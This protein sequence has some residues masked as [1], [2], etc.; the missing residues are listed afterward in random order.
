MKHALAG[1][2]GLLLLLAGLDA[3]AQ[4]RAWLDR[5]RI[6]FGE[7]ATLNIEVEGSPGAPDYSALQRDFRLSGHSSTR[8]FESVNG[9]S[10]ERSLYAVALQPRREGA[11]GIP[12]LQ[13]G[14]QRAPPLTLTV[15]PAATAPAR[16]GEAVFV[17]TEVDDPDPYVQQ[18]VGVVV[19]LYYAVPLVSGQLDQDPPDGASLQRVGDDLRYNRELAGRRYNVVERRY[20]LIPERSGEVTLPGA[21]FEGRGVPGFFDDLFNR[22]VGDALRARAAPRR[23]AVRPVPADAPQ[24]WLPLHQLRLR[25]LATPQS[26]RAGEAAT[27]VVEMVA[28][29]AGAAQLPPLE[30]QVGAGAQVFA[31][32]P[33]ADER[34]RDGR[35]QATVTRRFSLVPAQPGL[36]RVPGPV[37]EWWDVAGGQRRS[38]RLPA[39][40]LQVAPG[41]GGFA[42]PPA[43]DVAAPAPADDADR[44]L[45]VPGVQGRVHPWALATV[46]FAV[47]WLLT[48]AWGLGRRRPASAPAPDAAGGDRAVAPR[49]TAA[50]RRALDAGD[51]GAVADALRTLAPEPEPAGGAGLE[52]IAAQLDDAAQRAALAALQQ[53]RWGGGDPAAA[54]A[55]LRKAFARGPRWRRPPAPAPAGPLPPLYPR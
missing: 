37:V 45:R 24:P 16:A 33:Q 19:R 28:D 49:A 42:L 9:R 14:G 1:L 25:Y 20:L 39:L 32:P 40:D 23:L 6:A 7:T 53:A 12:A 48:L 8:R 17:E 27:V 35:P 13:V 15:T 11:I 34:F 46:G 44:W 21:R 3:R 54:R 18:A 10:V 2:F 52:G 41:Q 51:L 55:A 38:T 5:D 29:G 26:A 36:L 43:A 31:E 47:L 4:A 30:L 22:G 50:L